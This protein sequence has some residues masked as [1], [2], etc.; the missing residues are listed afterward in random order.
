MDISEIRK[1][2]MLALM[3]N[4]RTQSEFADAIN[5]PAS[6][7]SQLKK[8]FKPNGEKVG[9]GNDFARDIETSLNLDFG[10]MDVSHNQPVV[11]ANQFNSGVFNNTTVN[12]NVFS[13][14]KNNDYGRYDIFEISY[15]NQAT[16][17]DIL[18]YTISQDTL[19]GMDVPDHNSVFAVSIIG[20]EMKP[21][22]M[23]KTIAF[24]DKNKADL[25][26]YDGK[27]YALDFG[28][29]IRCRYLEQ[30]SNNRIRVYT[31]QNKEGE[32]LSKEDFDKQYQILGGLTGWMGFLNW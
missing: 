1:Q 2:N 32:I 22:L 14:Q 20:Q 28:G 30:M 11:H 19:S 17:K 31:E 10:W 21:V 9:M 23:D 24:I 8:G 4:F 18:S 27:I 26:I 13:S 15:F 16:T 5:K 12:Q 6:Y 25:T 3:S 29:F 7:I